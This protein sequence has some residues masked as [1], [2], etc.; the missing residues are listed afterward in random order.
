MPLAS[1]SAPHVLA[2]L[3]LIMPE[4]IATRL[5]IL[6]TLRVID[7]RLV[8]GLFVPLTPQSTPHML[9]ALGLIM[10]KTLATRRS[11]L[12]ALGKVDR[13]LLRGFVMT[14]DHS[15]PDMLAALGLLIRLVTFLTRLARGTRNR[16]QVGRLL[17][18]CLL[19]KAVAGI[20][21]TNLGPHAA[22]NRRAR[23]GKRR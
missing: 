19:L 21:G 15:G 10:P 23:S 16:T 5:T 13:R 8:H 18:L 3:G 22:G 12:S 20:A 11:T 6:S 9:A 2:A 4:T 17:L 7:T 14:I 1:H